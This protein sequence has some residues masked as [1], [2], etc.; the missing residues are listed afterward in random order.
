MVKHDVYT[1]DESTDSL[2]VAFP[3]E[4]EYQKVVP[5]KEDILVEIDTEGKPKAV[6]ILNASLNFKT[7]KELLLNPYKI[8]M[9]INVTDSDIRLEVVLKLDDNN[10]ITLEESVAKYDKSVCAGEHTLKS[11]V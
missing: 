6:E 10:T 2:F 4:Y 3:E 5:L 9:K 11:V 7:D 1:Y 8:F